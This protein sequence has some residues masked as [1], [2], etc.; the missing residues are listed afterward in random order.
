MC[1]M[2]RG[3]E[4]IWC[5][6]IHIL[7]WRRVCVRHALYMLSALRYRW[8]NVIRLEGVGH[9]S[10]EGLS[11]QDLGEDVSH[12]EDRRY[13]VNLDVSFLQVVLNP[14]DLKNDILGSWIS[15]LMLLVHITIVERLSS[16][17]LRPYR[18]DPMF[19]NILIVWRTD[20]T[21]STKLSSSVSVVERVSYVVVCSSR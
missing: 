7:W 14:F 9:A 15:G 8:K 11:W 21:Q 10:N 17:M 4:S 3:E 12:V 13:M 18:G 6:S 20:L 1:L 2:F 5:V 16:N 19:S